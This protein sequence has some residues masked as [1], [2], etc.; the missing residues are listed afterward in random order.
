MTSRLFDVDGRRA[1][2]DGFHFQDKDIVHVRGLDGRRV[3][4]L[5]IPPEAC[6]AAGGG[7]AMAVIIHMSAPSRASGHVTTAADLE[8]GY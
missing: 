2:L 3:S 4:L 7:V 5:V 6:G 8:C 1:R